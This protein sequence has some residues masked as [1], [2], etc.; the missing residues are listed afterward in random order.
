MGRERFGNKILLL[1]SLPEQP[2]EELDKRQRVVTGGVLA[3][4]RSFMDQMY[5]ANFTGPWTQS[6]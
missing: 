4:P 6:P 3:S 2:F 1:V 5:P